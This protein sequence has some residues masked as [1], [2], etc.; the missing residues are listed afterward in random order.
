MLPVSS[1]LK[2]AAPPCLPAVVYA[3]GVKL[4]PPWMAL[5]RHLT[6]HVRRE[7]EGQVRRF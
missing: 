6:P 3:S 1:F 2:M 4:F 7:L 5:Q